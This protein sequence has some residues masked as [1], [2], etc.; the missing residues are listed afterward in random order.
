MT[1]LCSL[2]S[3]S[4]YCVIR[5]Y[6]CH[7]NCKP[8]INLVQEVRSIIFTTRIDPQQ[9][10]CWIPKKDQETDWSTPAERKAE[11]WRA[12]TAAAA[13]QHRRWV[14]RQDGRQVILREGVGRDGFASARPLTVV[15][16]VIKV[17]DRTEGDLFLG[18]IS[19][20][21][22]ICRVHFKG[23]PFVFLATKNKKKIQCD[24]YGVFFLNAPK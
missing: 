15:V 6:I 17:W 3:C 20:F 9:A 2:P 14:S 11:R 13:A 1:T 24:S 19:F 10:S 12:T 23:A 8:R 16:Q 5:W 4:C 21:G 7:K 22:S 18:N